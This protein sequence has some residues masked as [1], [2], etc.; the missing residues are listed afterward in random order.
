[1]DL[2]LAGK[3][4]IVT[5]AG[6]GLGKAMAKAFAAEGAA[7]VIA[8]LIE[9]NARAVA[10]ELEAAGGK[11]LGLGASVEDPERVAAMVR[12]TIDRFGRVDVLVNNAGI[13]SKA[14]TQDVTME[15]WQKNLDV[16]LTGVFNCCR[17][18]MDGMME[19]RSGR[20]VNISS[21]NAFRPWMSDV[22]YVATK[23]GVVGLTR[24]LAKDLGPFGI[25]V[26]A[27]A[28]S[29]T[30]T[31][32]NRQAVSDRPQEELV[33]P[34]PLGR[35]CLPEDVAAAVMFLASDAASFITGQVLH[36]NGGGYMQ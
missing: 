23:A 28:P 12:A 2:G 8:D 24:K 15:W 9:A 20:I 11:A 36:V 19:R 25:T 10:A 34:F 29:L 13:N 1:M 14:A 17:A 32:L 7:V 5:G 16:N 18:V 26:N 30:I 4:A 6:R 35:L 21:Y 3:V 33:A 31:D 22:A 27:V